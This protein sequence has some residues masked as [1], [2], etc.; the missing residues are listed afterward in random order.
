MNFNAQQ[1]PKSGVRPS[2]SFLDR[3]W[4]LLVLPAR[5]THDDGH[6]GVLAGILGRRGR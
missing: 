5:K 6:R 1:R 2:I 3:G 4:R